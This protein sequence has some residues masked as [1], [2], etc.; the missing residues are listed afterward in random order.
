M[1]K[2]LLG[3]VSVV[4]MA[5]IVFAYTPTNEETVMVENLSKAFVLA[6]KYKSEYYVNNLYK[7]LKTIQIVYINKY[8]YGHERWEVLISMIMNKTEANVPRLKEMGWEMV[9]KSKSNL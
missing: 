6:E 9:N 3:L 4:F 2:L 1:K 7:K 8:G 5:G